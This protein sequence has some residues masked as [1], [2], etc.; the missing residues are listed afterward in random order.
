PGL[1]LPVV[2]CVAVA[3]LRAERSFVHVV[4]AVARAAGAGS[5]P[6]LLGGLVALLAHQL[7]VPAAQRVVRYVVVEALLVEQHDARRAAL[8]IGVAGAAER[9]LLLSPVVAGALTHVAPHF[10]VA[11]HAQPV[12]RSALEAHVALRAVFLP[13]GVTLDQLARAQHR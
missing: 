3:A 9:L 10:L 2:L 6:V 8:V 1:L 7:A 13:L 4:F 12:L 5:V 11:V